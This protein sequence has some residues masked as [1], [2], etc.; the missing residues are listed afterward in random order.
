MAGRAKVTRTFPQHPAG[1]AAVQGPGAGTTSPGLYYE[2]SQISL[3][4]ALVANLQNEG[5]MLMGLNVK[6][7]KDCLRFEV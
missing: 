1:P 3:I 5:L 7:L 2:F 6:V 4:M